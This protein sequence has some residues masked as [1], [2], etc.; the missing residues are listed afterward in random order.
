MTK[1]V[2]IF[3]AGFLKENSVVWKRDSAAEW[4]Q[5]GKAGIAKG[6]QKQCPHR[7]IYMAQK[8]RTY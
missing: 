3:K 7:R 5:Y 4:G 2:A 1:K 8:N 6:T